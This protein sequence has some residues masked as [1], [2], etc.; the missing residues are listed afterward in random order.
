MP[1]DR[2]TEADRAADAL[3]Y[4]HDLRDDAGKPLGIVHRDVSPDNLFITEGRSTSHLP[5]DKTPW[6]DI[7]SGGQGIALTRPHCP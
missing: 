6:R 3:A 1:R 4:A 2:V 7:W 5:P